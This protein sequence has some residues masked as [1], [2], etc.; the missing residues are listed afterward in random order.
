[1][2][3]TTRVW[4]GQQSRYQSIP[5]TAVRAADGWEGHAFESE[6]VKED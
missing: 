2:A 1:M 6:L 4:N 5:L 3:T